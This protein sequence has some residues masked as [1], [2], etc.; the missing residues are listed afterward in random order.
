MGLRFTMPASVA[1]SCLRRCAA[2]GRVAHRRIGETY[3]QGQNGSAPAWGR[4][5][6]SE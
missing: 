5:I 4:F 1:G 6:G 3:P 2:S